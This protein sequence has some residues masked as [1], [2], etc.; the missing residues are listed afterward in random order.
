MLEFYRTNCSRTAFPTHFVVPESDW[1]GLG[2]QIPVLSGGAAFLTRKQ[3][4]ENSF[5]SV[6]GIDVQ[7]MPTIYGMPDYNS[8]RG[9]GSGS[10]LNRYV[11]YKYDKNVLKQDMA[12][13]LMVTNP[14]TIDNFQFQC[15]G[16]SQ[17]SGVAAFKPTQICYFDYAAA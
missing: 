9:L 13:P 17:H 3:I 5:K 4:I 10:G 8:S 15:A 16:V 12:V 7:I 6:T 14:G 1:L 2:Q 11:M